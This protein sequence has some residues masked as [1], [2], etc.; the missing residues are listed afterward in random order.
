VPPP[1][2]AR[3][4]KAESTQASLIIRNMYT[5]RNEWVAFRFQ[6]SPVCH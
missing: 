2:L 3:T 5:L 4:A 1:Q 6:H